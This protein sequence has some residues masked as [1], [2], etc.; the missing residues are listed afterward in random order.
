MRTG[1]NPIRP[2]TLVSLAVWFCTLFYQAGVHLD[3]PPAFESDR[4][5]PFGP[6]CQRASL[7]I[8][9]FRMMIANTDQ[10]S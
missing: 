2:M 1:A 7:I 6:S 8:S 10:L 3:V 4:S 5:M 9:A